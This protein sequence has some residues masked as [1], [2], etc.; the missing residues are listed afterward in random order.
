MNIKDFKVG[1]TV[2]LM[3]FHG[4]TQIRNEDTIDEVIVVS[5]GK[6]YVKVRYPYA[7]YNITFNQRDESES[8]FVEKI[9]Y[10]V[11]N[12]LFHT[13]QDIDEY[14]ERKELAR[15]ICSKT[16]YLRENQYNLKQFREIKRILE[17]SKFDD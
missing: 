4:R 7:N 14:R 6:K 3:N 16:Q 5:I 8:Y 11:A 12:Y 15:W 17:K 1:E 13:Q 9:T 2:Y 10:G